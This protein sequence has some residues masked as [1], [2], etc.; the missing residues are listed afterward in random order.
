MG[1][2]RDSLNREASLF[3]L[4]AA[5]T[6]FTNFGWIYGSVA[7]NLIS[8]GKTRVEQR[9]RQAEAICVF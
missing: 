5:I 1:I 9:G 2:Q 7:L 3:Y 6:G 8:L 4:N